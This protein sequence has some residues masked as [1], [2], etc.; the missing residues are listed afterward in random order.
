MLVADVMFVT[1]IPFLVLAS[2]NINLITIEQA[3]KHHSASKLGYLLQRIIHVYARAGFRI[4]II[5]IDNEFDKVRDHVF[6][7]DMNT[8]TASEQTLNVT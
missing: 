8:P 7:I 4:Q 1:S 3:P 2:Y 5:L 6:T